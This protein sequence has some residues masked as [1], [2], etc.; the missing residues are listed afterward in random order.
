MLR[1][2]VK[3]RAPMYKLKRLGSAIVGGEGAWLYIMVG[4]NEVK[5]NSVNMNIKLDNQD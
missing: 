5:T 2:T 3:L 1:L 4:E